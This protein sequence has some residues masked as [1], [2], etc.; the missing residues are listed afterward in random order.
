MLYVFVLFFEA[1]NDMK[2]MHQLFQMISQPVRLGAQFKKQLGRQLLE[3]TKENYG[4]K[5]KFRKKG[6][7]QELSTL[8]IHSKQCT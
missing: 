1:W 2:P 5:C 3:F 6:N 4:E 8:L 7:R